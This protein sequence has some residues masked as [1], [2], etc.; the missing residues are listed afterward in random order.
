LTASIIHN[1]KGNPLHGMALV[2]DI[3]EFKRTQEEALNRNK[4][5]S[6]G[7]MAG[8]IAH[9][10]NNLLGGILAEA[11]LLENTLDEGL[12]PG[13]QI[14]RIK[15]V[16]VRGSEIVRELM[17]F[18]GQDRVGHVEPVHL[19]VLVEEMLELLKVSVS[20]QAVLKTALD[21]ALP[22]VAGNAGRIRQVVMNLVI[23]ASEAIGPKEG[24]IRI[25][26]SRF[27]TVPGATHNGA[28]N[29]P[30]GDYASLE[31][32]DSGSGITDEVRSKIFDPFF[33]T[34]F[35]GRGLGLA[36]VHRTVRDLGGDVVVE[37]TPGLGS[38]FRVLLPCTSKKAFE[39]P[40]ASVSAVGQPG[41]QAAT[42]LVVEDEEVLRQAVAKSLRK[43]GFAVLEAGDG[44]LAIDLCR[45]HKDSINII[46]LDVTLPGKSSRETLEEALRLRPGLKVILTSAYGRETVDASFNGLQITHF[47]RK[48]FLLAQLAGLLQQALAG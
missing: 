35:A 16:A 11:E 27:I 46:L 3:T 1:Q 47:I 31:V 14:G 24:V 36:V 6:L 2:E 18:A 29:L 7:L 28:L 34:K 44:S 48:P 33:S 4:L 17:I 32:S 22:P 5:E 42:V 21:R 15:A 19:S 26:T 30:D 10:F 39:G 25:A 8:G 41:S 9:D 23:N 43:R 45:A 12:E 38:T 20:K 13:D 37:S 40:P